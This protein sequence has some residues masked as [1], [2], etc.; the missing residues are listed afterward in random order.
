M[1]DMRRH[2]WL[3]LIAPAVLVTCSSANDAPSQFAERVAPVLQRRCGASTCHGVPPGATSTR[4]FQ[5]PT[6]AHGYLSSRDLVESARVA[7]L[8]FLDTTEEIGL[9]SLLR[10]PLPAEFGG[11]GHAGGAAYYDLQDPGYLAVRDWAASEH[12]TG[13]ED[14]DPSTLTEGQRFFAENVQR[15]LERAQ[16]MLSPC[17]G[18][19]AA[20]PLRFDPGFNGTFGV[21][22][23]R[24]NYT[25]ALAHL[26]LGGYPELSRLILKALP[27]T[28]HHLPHRG[29]NGIISFPQTLDDAFSRAIIAWARVERRIRSHDAPEHQLDGIVF[30]GGPVGPARVVEHDAFVPGSDLYLLAPPTSAG[31]T[32]NLTASL[33]A[34]PADIRN[35]AVSN[36][37]THVAFSMKTSATSGATLW[38]LDIASGTSR[39]LT[40]SVARPDGHESMDLW[41]AYGP[42]GRVW[43]VSDRA[44]MIAEHGDGF[45]TDIYVIETDGSLTRRTHTPSPELATTFIRSGNETTGSVAFTAIRRLGE[46]YK[47]VVYRFPPDLHLEYHPEFGV[48]AQVDITFHFRET[49]EGLFAAVLLD[50]DAVWSAGALAIIDRNLGPEL[51]PARAATSSLPRFLHPI[52]YLGP[53]GSHEESYLDPYGPDGYAASIRRT[54]SNGAYRDPSPLPDGR[55]AVSYAEG[56]IALRDRSIAPDF[57]LYVLTLGQDPV[58]GEST[59]ASR[60]RLVDLPGVSETEPVPVHYQVPGTAWP[61]APHGETGNLSLGGMSMI[62]NILHQVGAHGPR[63]LRSDIAGLRALLWLPQAHNPLFADPNPALYPEQRASG[64]TPHMPALVVAEAPLESDS[65]LFVAV[66]AGASFRAQF[67]DARGMVVGAQYNRW[68]DINDGQDMRV[69]VQP[70]VFDFVCNVCHGARSGE[71]RH[72]FAPVDL[73]TN[74]S[75]SLARLVNND[76]ARPR[77]PI[78]L[79]AATIRRSEW[80]TDVVPIL[81]RSCATASC[82]DASSRAGGLALEA[83]PTTRYDA[84]YE[85]LVALGAGSANGFRYIDVVGTRARASYL[86]ERILGEE[87]EATRALPAGASPHRGAPALTEGELHTIIRWIESGALFCATQGPCAAR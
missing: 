64:A 43:F 2:A 19:V 50:R 70:H 14:Q 7:S 8:R 72:A 47:G 55:L 48:T 24:A 13:G 86:V 1:R 66:P 17:H 3:S 29:G 54:T 18:A 15:P 65:S 63:V 25:A 30:V 79:G 80:S 21:R 27:A 49:A 44:G 73:N 57:G 74:P 56:T 36:D 4:L 12:G 38:E 9:S 45:D 6:D 58:T 32:R 28:T 60:E 10:K 22:A 20:S 68:F 84:A 78:A 75:L 37:G 42:D 52:S 67:L 5:F 87:L 40:T 71:A 26:S 76:P 81:A 23:T 11:V 46:G 51:T 41:P 85:A 39:Q 33:H 53:Y 82:H 61:A 16:C 62:E 35:P 77:Q 31:T 34:A 83:R 59:I 69:G